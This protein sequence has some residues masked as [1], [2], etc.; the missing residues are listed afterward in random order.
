MAAR[1]FATV[2]SHL[3]GLWMD[4]APLAIDRGDLPEDQEHD[5]RRERTVDRIGPR[6]PITKG[7]QGL[8]RAIVIATPARLWSHP[9]NTSSPSDREVR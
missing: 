7:E 2:A 3:Y 8:P 4:N 9:Q 6:S 5:G 1:R